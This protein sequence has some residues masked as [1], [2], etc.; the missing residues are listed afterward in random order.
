ML[1]DLHIHTYYSDGT[2]SPEEVVKKAK[3]KN[4]EII[5]ITD[6]NNIDSWKAFKNEALKEGL[7]PIKG[8]EINV[9]FK[10]KV[11]H[12]LAYNFKDNS[13]LLSM[14]NKANYEMQKMSTDL[15]KN[16]SDYNNLVS[17]SDFENYSYNPKK[18][19][20][21]GLHY[22]L[23]RGI[24]N[25]LFDGFY[26]YKNYSCGYELYDFP[27]LKD[28]CEA[29]NLS[30]GYSILAHPGEYYKDLS[31][32]ELLEELHNLKDYGIDGIE[33]YYPTHNE[34]ITKTCVDFCKSN[35]LLITSGGDDH[36]E[37]GKEAKS[38]EQSIGCMNIDIN[39]LN[40]DLLLQ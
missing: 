22:L 23:D 38:L 1:V 16:L 25:K 21:K 13:Q 36:G 11:L 40:I 9:K 32:Q 29:I 17:L 35:N 28:V 31:K 26:Y 18:G 4:V 12:L 37:F 34:L 30:G 19:G 15:I 39:S 6:H 20:W 3:S 5:S 10:D 7:I 27:H 33:C 2:M 24:T 8:V 14:I